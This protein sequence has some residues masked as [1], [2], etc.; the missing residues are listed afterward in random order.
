MLGGVDN[1]D[2]CKGRLQL[3]TD[4]RPILRTRRELAKPFDFCAAGRPPPVVERFVVSAYPGSTRS[5]G[6]ARWRTP[7]SSLRNDALLCVHQSGP[8]SKALSFAP[9]YCSR[10]G[11]CS[12]GRVSS[13]N[14]TIVVEISMRIERS[15]LVVAFAQALVGRDARTAPVCT[16]RF[17]VGS[18]FTGPGSACTGF[19]ATVSDS[20]RRVCR[21]MSLSVAIPN[22]TRRD[23][24]TATK[25]PKCSKSIV[26]SALMVASI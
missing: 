4:E 23:S 22:L 16:N 3:R 18:S 9:R 26:G 15:G 13:R 14:P 20:V 17:C 24:A 7:F 19:S 21:T 8:R 6:A 11:A 5:L 2:K 12:D 1:C 10:K 25:L